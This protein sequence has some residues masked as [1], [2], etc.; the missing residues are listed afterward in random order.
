MIELNKV[1]NSNEDFKRNDERS[2]GVIPKQTFT[3]VRDQEYNSS[4]I[5]MFDPLIWSGFPWTERF[6]YK[7]CCRSRFC[8]DLTNGQFLIDDMLS[9]PCNIDRKIETKDKCLSIKILKTGTLEIEPA[10]IH[11]FVRIS[12]I[13]LKTCRYLQKTNF[14]MPSTLINEKN[15]IVSHNKVQ[16]I[17]EYKESCLDFLPPLC[18][19]PNDLRELGESYAKWNEKFIINDEAKNI[20]SDSTIIFFELLDFNFTRSMYKNFIEDEFSENTFKIAWGYL[21]PMGYSQ[22]Y[23]GKFKVQLYKYKYSSPL[24]MKNL[25]KTNPNY[26]RTPKVLYEFNWLKKE[27]YQT[28]IE[29]ELKLELKPRLEDMQN[30]YIKNTFRNSVFSPETQLYDFDLAKLRNDK[31]KKK[32]KYEEEDQS[33]IEKR[34][35][36]LKFKKG[37]SEECI[38]PNKLLYKFSTG[39]AGCLTI[40]F[41]FDGKYLAAA[42]TDNQSELN[43][44]KIFNVEEGNLKYHFKGHLGLIHNFSWSRD[45]KILYSASSDNLVKLWQVPK[46]DSNMAENTDYLDNDRLFLL[47]S[48]SH[49]SYVYY[50][51]LYPEMDKNIDIIATACFDGNVRLYLVN[52]SYDQNT[53]KYSF[54]NTNLVR[55]ISIIEELEKVDFS[56]TVINNYKKYNNLYSSRGMK[57][58]SESVAL[59]QKTILDHRHPNSL[60][61]DEIGRLFI[62]DSLGSIHMWQLSINSGKFLINKLQLISHKELEGDNINKLII[63]PSEKKRLVV[64]SRDNCIR[65]LDISKDKPKVIVRYFGSKTSR[66][67]IKSVVSP[68]GQYLLAASEDGK[69]FLWSFVSGTSLSTEKYE[70]DFLDLLSDVTW[71]PEYNMFAMCGFGRDYPLL[72]YVYEKNEAS[73]DP[74]D[75]KLKNRDKILDQ[76]DILPQD[77]FSDL[78]RN[79]SLTPINDNISE[80]TKELKTLIEPQIKK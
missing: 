29:V 43:T 16:N 34:K 76:S 80:F 48:I 21:K 18:T 10:I 24:A 75:L 69:P 37:L 12:F 60:V 5:N 19:P 8:T 74:A 66:T 56:A 72:V 2:G 33:A 14:E 15:L 61:F 70:C 31:E 9:H 23:L 62:G 73:I 52:F 42:C 38:L 26:F 78:N 59:L 39:K 65:L 22:T 4:Q 57:I 25:R 71:N 54:L 11:P 46:E 45:S 47:T 3:P 20:L 67:N 36:L 55:K 27:K 77:D 6:W 28:F 79:K 7:F 53:N 49:P 41:S 17:L 30:L 44:I 35:R 64:H 32:I 63:E 13:N 51:S 68:D 58:E 40:E 1:K 50:V